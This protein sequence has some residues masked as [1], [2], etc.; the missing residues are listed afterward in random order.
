[1]FKNII[2]SALVVT[3]VALASIAIGQHFQVKSTPSILGGDAMNFPAFTQDNIFQVGK[4]FATRIATLNKGRTYLE[5]GNYS[6]ATS[7]PQAIYCK[8][9]AVDYG[10]TT[11]ALFAFPAGN[12][13]YQGFA[14]QASSSKVFN[15]GTG[16]PI[17]PIYCMNPLASS[18]VSVVEY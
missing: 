4:G 8:T 16:S 15:I 12:A 17:S 11:T 9:S 7:T 18:T 10:A 1:M 3:S 13:S 6:G 2:I 5:I 14:V